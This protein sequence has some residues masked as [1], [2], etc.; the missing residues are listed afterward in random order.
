MSEQHDWFI[1]LTNNNTT[2]YYHMCNNYYKYIN[3][4][5]QPTNWVFL[6]VV[7]CSLTC[8]FFYKM[9]FNLNLKEKKKWFNNNIRT[10]NRYTYETQCLQWR[11][12]MPE[13]ISLNL[14]YV[15][16]LQ[17]M[18]TWSFPNKLPVTFVLKLSRFDQKRVLYKSAFYK[19]RVGQTPVFD[20]TG[21]PICMI[22]LSNNTL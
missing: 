22:L 18:E 7:G 16:D 5:Y 1:V 4:N 15:T 8:F 11:V 17:F 10:M 19:L 3:E 13:P 20:K 2:K 14:M 12:K 21:R 6:L 9:F